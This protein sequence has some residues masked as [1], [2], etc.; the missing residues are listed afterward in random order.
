LYSYTAGDAGYVPTDASSVGRLSPPRPLGYWEFFSQPTDFRLCRQAQIDFSRGKGPLT[1]AV[2]AGWTI[3][4]NDLDDPASIGGLSEGD[5]VYTYDRD[6][7][8]QLTDHLE[9]GQGA[10]LY[11]PNGGTVTLARQSGPG[12]A[13]TVG[14]VV[15]GRAARHRAQA[16][17]PT[18]SQDASLTLLQAWDLFTAAGQ[19]W[20]AGAQIV[21]LQSAAT[22]SDDATAEGDGTRRSWL[23]TLSAPNGA[24]LVLHSLGSTIDRQSNGP[25]SA[26]PQPLDRPLVDS[27]AALANP[28]MIV[29]GTN[30]ISAVV[31]ASANDVIAMQ[32]AL[33][34]SR[35]NKWRPSMN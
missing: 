7:D 23:A 13:G 34:G 26:G 5:A 3:I 21:Q 25:A 27:P 20:Q 18:G 12:I 16:E 31:F 14:A 24:S 9:L 22:I 33:P 11:S 19:K 6:V 1:F 30:E 8:Y 29:P 2:T 10:F 32:A 15:P 28:S 35:Q 17:P 4:G